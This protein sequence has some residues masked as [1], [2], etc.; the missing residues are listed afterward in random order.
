MVARINSGKSISK[1][2]NYNEQKVQHGIAELLT[3]SGFVKDYDKLTFYDKINH[4]NRYTSLN[5]KVVTNTLHVSL[6]FDPSEVLENNKLIAIAN[7]YMNRIGFGNQPYLVYRHFDTGH[8]HIHIVSTNIEADGS[9]ISLHNIGRN[10]SESARKE[11]EIQFDLVKADS[12]K[13]VNQ[14]NIVPVNAQKLMSGKRSTKAAISN[15]LSLVIDQYKYCSL[16]EFNA[17]LKLYNVSADRCS[18]ISNTYKFNGLLFRVLDDR[19]NKTG[20][21]IKASLFYMKPTLSNLEKRFQ[22][23]EKLK[24]PHTKRLRTIIDYTLFKNHHLTIET[25]IRLLQQE[26][27]STVLR[28]NKEGIIYGVT[29][30]DHKTKCVFNGSELGNGYSA[31]NLLE[32]CDRDENKISASISEQTKKNQQSEMNDDYSKQQSIGQSKSIEILNDVIN[33]TRTI[34]YVP[35][36]LTKAS[37]RKK[38]KQ[39]KI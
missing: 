33:P 17:V 19:G 29:Y 32:K 7:E 2:L 27:I 36:Q 31:K 37:K 30:V 39:L 4:F 8:P 35:Y 15:V 11:I 24:T 6:N 26:G 12:S 16:A 18:E 20:T 28:I 10:Q 22:E 13:P 23:N 3:A 1:A 38:K 9:R 5:D 25:F 14:L 21:P 34:D